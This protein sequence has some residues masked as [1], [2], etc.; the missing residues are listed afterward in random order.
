MTILTHGVKMEESEGACMILMMTV[1]TFSIKYVGSW[2]V[3]HS[4]MC[5]TISYIEVKHC[6]A[7][8]LTSESPD[9]H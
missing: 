4:V 6:F 7:T 8:Y 1:G 3:G 2:A 5:V 9:E